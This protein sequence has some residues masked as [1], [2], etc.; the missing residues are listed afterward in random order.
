MISSSLL[1]AFVGMPGSGKS[2]ASSYLHKKGISIVRLGDLTEEVIK[3]KNML[4]TP[5]NEE[6]I[7][8]ALRKEF[9][10]GIYAQK[11][12]KKIAQLYAQGSVII[13]GLYSWEEYISLKKQFSSLILIHIFAEPVIRYERLAKR[14]VRPFSLEDAKKRDIAEIEHLNKGGPI[15]M[16]DFLVVNNTTVD[17][18]Y[19]QLDSLEEGLSKK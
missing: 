13:D 12:G 16:A 15:A 6:K 4:L 9:G 10:M 1:L 7:R 18:L 11:A 5:E 17:D 8:E 3:E 2:E 19:K 14:K